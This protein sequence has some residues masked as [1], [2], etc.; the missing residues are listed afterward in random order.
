MSTILYSLGLTMI[1]FSV[2]RSTSIILDQQPHVIMEPHPIQCGC[3][4]Q[5][6][7]CIILPVPCYS[8]WYVCRLKTILSNKWAFLFSYFRHSDPGSHWSGLIWA[9][10]LFSAAIA[11]T[12]PKPTGIRTLV[13]TLILRLIFSVGPHPTLMLLGFMAVS[14]VGT[15]IL[16]KLTWL[17]LV[18]RLHWPN[19]FIYD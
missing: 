10:M 17:N 9:V 4:H 14:F 6:N 5:F 18:V 16:T 11:I 2:H 19:W 7:C 3:H 13:I 1:I 12:L 8:A 15:F